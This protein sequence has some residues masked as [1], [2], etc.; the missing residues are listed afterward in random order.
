LASDGIQVSVAAA[1]KAW[2]KLGILVRHPDGKATKKRRL[3][4]GWKSGTGAQAGVACYVFKTE[5]P[6]E[7]TEDD[8]KA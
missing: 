3:T 8:A 4:T 5:L 6:D 1:E 7:V 2:E